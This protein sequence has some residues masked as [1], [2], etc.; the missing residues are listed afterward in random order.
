MKKA[1][2]AFFIPHRGCPFA[3][4]FCDQQKIS[5]KVA[6][7]RGSDV[8]AATEAALL[9][10]GDRRAEIAF[11]G[12]SFTGIPVKEQEELLDAASEFV[13]RGA[14]AGIRLSTRPD[15]IDAGVLDRLVRYGVTAVELGAQSM[16]DRVLAACGRGHTAAD[17]RRASRMIRER[18]ISL[19]LQMM[20]GLPEATL[21]S[22]LQ[23]AKKIIRLKPDAVRIYPTL[24]LSG[25]R[26]CREYEAGAYRPQETEEAV[27]RAAVLKEMFDAAG[28]SILRIGLHREESLEASLVAG[29]YHPAFG[30]LVASRVIY[31]KMEALLRKE[32]PSEAVI[33]APPHL[34]S[35]AVGH[36]KENLQNIER[37]FHIPCRAVLG[38]GEDILL[39]GIP[40]PF[41]LQTD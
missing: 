23:S 35:R 24:V 13:R 5:G 39:N 36:K 20:T 37:N 40:I 29:P 2:I 25:T 33:T 19:G 15:F 8:R 10:L 7:V 31:R 27:E 38:A 41:T 26:L 21:E 34:L 18:G 11:F 6:R 28:I 17:V 9:T 12:G 30:E 1:N 22:D 32:A 4:A 3:C 14:V 16:D